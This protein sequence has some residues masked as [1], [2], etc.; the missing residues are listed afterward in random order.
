MKALEFKSKIKGD[1][2]KIPRKIQDQL[3]NNQNV[4]V[5]VIMLINE[6]QIKDEQLFKE[7]AANKFFKGYA[8]SDAIYDKC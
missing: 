3:S 5:K 8:D 1:S 4:D 2:I 6:N 7:T